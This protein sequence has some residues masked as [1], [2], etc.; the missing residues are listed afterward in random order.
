MVV[1]STADLFD[2]TVPTIKTPNDSPRWDEFVAGPDSSVLNIEG[3]A[4]ATRL[5]IEDE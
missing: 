1:S 3:H 5:S 4:V 2:I